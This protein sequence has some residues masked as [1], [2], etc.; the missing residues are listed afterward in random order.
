MKKL[1]FEDTTV[2]KKPFVEI[3]GVEYEVQDGEFE[4]GTDLNAQNFNKI[5]DN[6]EEAINKNY[7]SKGSGSNNTNITTTSYSEINQSTNIDGFECKTGKLLISTQ[8]TAY[9]SSGVG[10]IRVS[11]TN[12][13][14]NQS[15]VVF[16]GQ[17][18]IR[19][20][21]GDSI[22][23]LLTYELPVGTYNIRLLGSV[24][25][26]GQTLYI[27]NYNTTRLTVIEI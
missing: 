22:N 11:F 12:T 13:T 25:T 15:Y 5:Q 21:D 19:D 20:T 26:E 4:G 8:M 6:I 24:Q 16:V 1:I 3:D 18:N 2:I 23:F 17:T 10:Y 27:K 7:I 9:V 14:T